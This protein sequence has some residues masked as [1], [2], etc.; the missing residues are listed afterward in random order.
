MDIEK[1]LK[2]GKIHSKVRAYAK[3]IIKKDAPLLEIA[4]KIEDK[5]VELGGKPAFPTNLNIDS[6]AAH[7]T[8]SHD[9][10]TL[11]KGLLKV[12]IG[13]HVDGWS[14]DAAF[15]V[16]L[17]NDEENKKIILA[18][19]KA[20]ENVKKIMADKISL[21]EIGKAISESIEG[22]DFMPIV[23]LTGHG[24]DYFELHASPS[25]PNIPEKS[26]E[27]LA[28]G[29]YAVEPF[30]TNGRGLVRDGK[31]SGIY[32]LQ[33]DKN[34]RSPIAREVLN[35][36]IEEYETLPFCSRWIVKKFGPKALFGL[37][38]LEENG[39]LHQF[40]QLIE[41]SEGKVSQAE[42]TFLIHNGKVIVTTE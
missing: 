37:R 34:V 41:V 19:E 15:S 30:A 3:S 8:P 24:I 28:E 21:D 7:Y 2:A 23:N 31:P 39:N 12:D 10:K 42:H 1:I 22:E 25:I 29:I 16:D 18:S 13:V 33:S 32:E 6:L 20:L 14:A 26:Q 36:I 9:D 38:Q 35:F 27:I 17:E 11:A 5:I 40:P 4:E